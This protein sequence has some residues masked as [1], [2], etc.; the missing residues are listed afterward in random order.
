MFG[1]NRIY[2]RILSIGE[3]Q[4]QSIA[5]FVTQ[6]TFTFIGFLSTMY[7]AHTLGASILG[8]YFLFTAYFG[9]INIVTDGGF[10][11]AAIKRMSE[12][13]EQ[14]AYFSAFFVIRSLFAIIAIISLIVF[15]KHFVDLN[16]TGIFSW[17]ILALIVS[18]FKGFIFNG[19]AGRG[20]MGIFATGSFIDNF[21]RVVI[22]IVAVFLGYSIEGLMGGFVVGM[23]IA[24]ISILRFFDLRIVYF[25][26]RHVKSL[27]TFSFWLFLTS[28]GV[29]LYTYADSIMIGY[30]MGNADVG[31]YRVVFQFTTISVIV[32][33]AFRSTLWPKISRWSKT[34]EIKNI[35]ESL[36]RAS[37]YSLILPI[38][39][40]TGG[41]LLGDKLLFFLY[42]TEFTKGYTV[43]IVLVDF[44][45]ECV[46][47]FDKFLTIY[48]KLL[49]KFIFRAH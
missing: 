4:R 32:T 9:I 15:R 20:K 47:I 24:T 29:M 21:S 38:P 1:L 5:S 36:S 45:Q 43:L 2:S 23:F 16:S 27:S 35:E 39:I 18:Q 12:G 26:W 42:G 40:F 7:F 44:T 34:G 8:A 11:Y 48:F 10:G 33:S 41:V 6:I 14:N 25:K 31:V 13:K 17:F 30:F 49:K 46:L 3:V 28:T 22:Q 37:N 19:V